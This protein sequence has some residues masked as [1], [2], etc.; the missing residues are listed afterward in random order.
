MR[1]LFASDIFNFQDFQSSQ[2]N[3]EESILK[4]EALS[5]TVQNELYELINGDLVHFQKVLRGVC[6]IDIEAVK[7]F[8]SQ[9]EKEKSIKEV[10]Y[11]FNRP[12]LFSLCIL[13]ELFK[14]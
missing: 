9:F 11:S 3:L 12:Y 2:T 5:K 14:F 7:Q 8:R 13:E 10:T 6:E 4:L 1:E